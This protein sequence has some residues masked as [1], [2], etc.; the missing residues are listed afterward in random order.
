MPQKRICIIGAGPSGITALK[1]VLDEGLE[2]ICYDRNDEVGGNWLYSEEITHSSV[3]ETT[4]IISSKTLSQYE[5][6]TFDDFDTQVS[7][8]PSHRELAAYFQAYARRFDLYRHIEFGTEV[9]HAERLG[10]DQWEITI[11]K[12]DVERTET[13]T[14]LIVCNGHH[15]NP[16]M[17][18][19]PV[20][21]S[22]FPTRSSTSPSSTTARGPYRST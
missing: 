10:D 1:N 9:L 18:A 13:F 4:H 7:D 11:R 20:R 3:F 12:D 6:F 14:D 21:A 17:P 5:D 16:R 15:W 19:S 2:V 22:L 8:Y